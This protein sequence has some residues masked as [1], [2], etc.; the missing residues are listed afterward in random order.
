MDAIHWLMAANAAL[1][2]GLGAFRF[3]LLGQ[4]RALAARLA[5][6]AAA[7]PPAAANE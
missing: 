2:I 6:L 7:T 1:W 3:F 4:P 5:R